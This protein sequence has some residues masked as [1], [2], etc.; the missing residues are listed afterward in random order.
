M[1][2]GIVHG[3][4][5]VKGNFLL[6]AMNTGCSHMSPAL[7]TNVT[8][9]ELAILRVDSGEGL[10]DNCGNAIASD[11]GYIKALDMAVTGETGIYLYVEMAAGSIRY[12]GQALNY[13]IAQQSLGIIVL[14]IDD[15]VTATHPSILWVDIEAFAK[16]YEYPP[17]NL[18]AYYP[19]GTPGYGAPDFLLLAHINETERTGIVF[20]SFATVTC[21]ASGTVPRSKN[22]FVT[23]QGCIDT[24]SVR[25][26]SSKPAY[27]V[28][29]GSA[30]PSYLAGL[31]ACT[32]TACPARYYLAGKVCAACHYSCT[33]CEGPLASQCL[34]CDEVMRRYDSSTHQCVC[35]PDTKYAYN[36]GCVAKCNSGNMG[37]T[38]SLACR[39][40]CPSYTFHHVG[41][42]TASSEDLTQMYVVGYSGKTD[43][44]EFSDAS[45]GY[46]TLPGPSG[47]VAVPEQFTVSFWLY[48]AAGWTSATRTLLWGFNTFRIVISTSG[49]GVDTLQFVLSSSS[50]LTLTTTSSNGAGLIVGW[51]YIAA[52]VRRTA[53]TIDTILYTTTDVDSPSLADRSTKTPAF[54]YP[55]YANS[56]LVSCDGSFDAFYK[57]LTQIPSSPFSAYIRELTYL[58]HYNELRSLHANKN[59][60]YVPGL[61]IYAQLLSYW[62][63]DDIQGSGP[64]VLRDG[65]K[66]ALSV[67]IPA[68]GNPTKGSGTQGS[69]SSHVW[70]N[71]GTC[72]DLFSVGQF[73]VASVNVKGFATDCLQ[74][75]INM[76]D[77]TLLQDLLTNDDTLRFYHNGCTDGTFIQSLGVSLGANGVQFELGK[78]LPLSVFGTYVDVCYFSSILSYP[79]N[80]GQVYFPSIP[81]HITPSH[82]A[83]DSQTAS[84]LK[85]SLSGGDQ[86]ATDV[87]LM[88]NIE[89]NVQAKTEDG[90]LVDETLSTYKDYTMLRSPIDGTYSISTAGLDVGTYTL[91][92]RPS[93]LN[94]KCSGGLIEYKNL[95][96]LWSVEAAPRIRFDRLEDGT[97]EN[98]VVFKSEFFEPE[99]IGAGQT[100]GDQLLFCVSGCHYKNKRGS[101]YTRM[102]GKFPPVWLGEEFGVSNLLTT[103]S[104][105]RLFI[106]WRPA[107]RATRIS[108]SEDTWSMVTE[109][110]VA[111]ERAYI[112]V[113]SISENSGLSELAEINPPFGDRVLHEGQSVWFRLS[114]CE[115]TRVKPSCDESGTPGKVQL[116]RLIYTSS[117]LSTYD[118]TVV[119]EQEFT[120]VAAAGDTGFSVGKLYGNPA[121]CNFTLTE[122][123]PETM[124]PGHTYRLIIYSRSFKSPITNEYFLGSADVGIPQFQYEFVYQE[125]KYRWSNTLIPPSQTELEIFGDNLG[126][127]LV[128]G[129]GY[130]RLFGVSISLIATCG[131]QNA[132]TSYRVLSLKAGNPGSIK[133]TDL[134]LSSCRGRLAANIQ[135]IKLGECD[136][137]P[138]WSR[139]NDT[140]ELGTLGCYDLCGTCKGTG[141]YDCTS[142]G[143][144]TVYQYLYKG[145]CSNKCGGEM[146]YAFKNADISEVYFHCL[147]RCP[148]GYFANPLTN[149]CTACNPQCKTCSSDEIMSCTSCQ[150]IAVTPDGWTEDSKIYADKYYFNHMCVMK[151]PVITNDISAAHEDLVAVNNI[152][153]YCVLNSPPMGAYP[154]YVSIQPLSY[155]SRVNLQESM[156]IRALVEDPTGTFAGI[157]WQAH[158]AED[159]TVSEFNSSDQRTFSSYEAE[160]LSRQVVGINMNSLNYKTNNDEKHI[161]VKVRTT[162]SMAIA[163]TELFG[164]LVVDFKKCTFTTSPTEL[165]AMGHFDISIA[166]AEDPDDDQTWLKFRVT[167]KTVSLAVNT[168]VSSSITL[169][170]ELTSR[171]IT[172]YSTRALST[173]GTNVLLSDIY[174]PPLIDG[175]QTVVD[176]ITTNIVTCDLS[177]VAEDSFQGNSLYTFS[178]NVTDPYR[179]VLRAQ[180]LNDL[181][182]EAQLAQKHTN[183]S[184]NLALKISNTFLTIVASPKLYYLSYSKCARDSQ[185]GKGKCVTAGG[186]SNCICEEG[187]V[188]ESC[189]WRAQELIVAQSLARSVIEFLNFTLLAPVSDKLNQPQSGFIVDDTGTLLELSNVLSGILIN[190]EL[191]GT[192]LTL[193]LVQ[194]AEYGAR[195]SMHA[196]LRMGEEDKVNILKG[197]DAVVK[198]LLRHMKNEIYLYYLLHDKKQVS[199]EYE[200]EYVKKREEMS[201]FVLR[202]RNSLYSFLNMISVGYYAGDSAF[203]KK[204][205]TFEVFVVAETKDTMFADLGNSLAIQLPSETGLVRVPQSLI[206]DLSGHISTGEEFMLR[207]VNWFESP[208]VFSTSNPEV[209][210]SVQ[211]VAILTNNATEISL[212]LSEPIILFLPATNWTKNF[213]QEKIKCK[214]LDATTQTNVT[215]ART[216]KKSANL[217]SDSILGDIIETV[218]YYTALATIPEFVYD[219]GISTYGGVLKSNDYLGYVPC[220]VYHFGE[221][222]AVVDRKRSLE[223]E[224]KMKNFYYYYDALAYWKA[225]LGFYTC[226]A[227]AG[228]FG[229]IYIASIVLDKLLIPKLEKL[230]EINR[231]DYAQGADTEMNDNMTKGGACETTQ[232]KLKRER[233][234]SSS[235]KDY[236]DSENKPNETSS[237]GEKIERRAGSPH[238]SSCALP[239]KLSPDPIQNP[240]IVVS[241]LE[242]VEVEQNTEVTL[243]KIKDIKHSEMTSTQALTTQYPSA[244][245]MRTNVGNL[246]QAEDEQ[247]EK[248]FAKVRAVDIRNKEKVDDRGDDIFSPAHIER[249]ERAQYSLINLI[250]QG[251]L[252]TN[253]FLRTSTTLHRTTRCLTLF[254]N[255]YLQMFWGAVFIAATQSPLDHPDD[256]SGVTKMMGDKMWLPFAAPGFSTLLLYLFAALFKV[257]DDRVLLT[258]TFEQ[259]KRL[260]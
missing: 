19:S 225:S 248:S 245:A 67:A 239:I 164:N 200:V 62:R 151:C 5:G 221:V 220:A 98:G 65:S 45:A 197:I 56:M 46:L 114:K 190:P 130:K 14:T 256:F 6:L 118:K 243:N 133:L 63:F 8:E 148:D 24:N 203:R 92:W 54:T 207:V 105:N 254:L 96:V 102:S 84:T 110:T 86:S 30:S 180:I 144:A 257:S 42:S 142:C 185:C 183:F 161:I 127:V 230:I 125:A 64:Y 69:F 146:P 39:S 61:E 36:G 181:H 255:I 191:V 95:F 43:L 247:D 55:S 94:Q 196:A 184:W 112:T 259:Y 107:A 75:K 187:Y 208:Y 117:D 260:Q 79:V 137:R 201:G 232:T 192:D 108:P 188:G 49:T 78:R 100:D 162:D 4:S 25:C 70:D 129:F 195:I 57:T 177:V 168:A 123:P 82:G 139:T 134:D 71:V 178:V 106:C 53:S 189:Q 47:A 38:E 212:S 115:T 101:P 136:E 97:A 156:K 204:F 40:V 241:T 15:T 121:T 202:V 143:N 83:T 154:I 16:P 3:C 172:L 206:N 7:K 122:L 258:R 104:D 216:V 250:L 167:L 2:K 13:T 119:W 166:K 147:S 91:L 198:C 128:P 20:Y 244:L 233:L 68:G 209:Y 219:N 173:T 229:L 12:A 157:S 89:T 29:C 74:D 66:S 22:P 152:T 222:A 252:F 60:A 76:Y 228:L 37:Y 160:Y 59:R 214:M 193:A 23:D 32:M 31:F 35:A 113:D 21:N 210:T 145:E 155:R 33:T 242:K 251:N 217:S 150:S 103:T 176:G 234:P 169:S 44:L 149:L 120:S 131:G 81:A 211:N 224:D 135:L 52:S 194:L 87:L 215:R 199:E 205:D 126:D 227:M 158:P 240:N 18:L 48:R 140:L 88:L 41:Y 58:K 171:T 10:L 186:R 1:G 213:P 236:G 77:P 246:F 93:F 124:L 218:E 153:R 80:L 34:S 163:F 223:R 170:T 28:H 253:L 231:R 179:S 9:I 165:S 226:M 182:V 111:A 50:G 51:N 109:D 72:V 238:G 141:K 132:S 116:V 159:I 249:R 138:V 26:F 17:T 174:I 11:A 237:D 27:N 235:G 85:F 90:Y 175:P 99:L 73:P